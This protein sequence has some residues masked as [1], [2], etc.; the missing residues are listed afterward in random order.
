MVASCGLYN[1]GGSFFHLFNHAFFKA[2]LFLG[3]GSVIHALLDEQDLRK[4]GF[5]INFLP[6]TYITMFVGSCSLIGF[7]F[8]SGFYSK[9]VLIN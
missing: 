4:Y 2:I 7:P 8:L 9:D 1:F 3:A 5:L 6:F